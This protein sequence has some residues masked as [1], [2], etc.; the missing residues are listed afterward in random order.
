M[1]L[2][3]EKFAAKSP[4]HGKRFWKY[5]APVARSLN[6]ATG[7][8]TRKETIGGTGDSRDFFKFSLTARSSFDLSLRKLRSNVD[9]VLLQ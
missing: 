8:K 5:V 6:L 4:L 2:T 7:A 9:V 1:L 3:R